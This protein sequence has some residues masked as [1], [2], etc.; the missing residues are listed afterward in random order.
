MWTL[1]V[2]AALAHVPTIASYALAPA[3]TGW[4]LDV[5]L[6]TDG[7]H[8]ALIHRQP[9][10]AWSELS[11]EAYEEQLV[12]ALHEGTRLAFDG[13]PA[14]LSVVAVSVAPHASQVQLWVDAPRDASV[15]EAHIDALRGDRDQHN[16]LRV[17]TPE[18]RE[19][20]VLSS[21]N[22]FRGAV[23]LRPSPAPS[24]ALAGG[25]VGALLTL[26][27]LG[28]AWRTRRAREARTA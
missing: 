7:M 19:H 25:G 9:D 16:V 6:P 10:L 17:A 23:A 5:T 12:A 22:G 21:D 27:T 2:A 13:V 24:K 28:A 15:V 26:L 4:A 18:H 8:Q 11:V 1:L 3:D 20:V 14:E